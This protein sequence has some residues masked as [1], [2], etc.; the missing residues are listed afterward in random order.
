MKKTD[1][2]GTGEGVFT[3][4]MIPDWGKNALQAGLYI[5]FQKVGPLS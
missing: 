2:E 4:H 5:P 3:L 1:Q